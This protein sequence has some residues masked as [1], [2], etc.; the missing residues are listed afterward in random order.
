MKIYYAY[1]KE[2]GI[3]KKTSHKIGIQLGGSRSKK[4]DNKG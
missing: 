3:N 4:D 1:G 2:S